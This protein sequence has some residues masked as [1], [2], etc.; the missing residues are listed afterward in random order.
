MRSRLLKHP[1][2]NSLV[3]GALVVGL[4]N[5]LETTLCWG[6]DFL[7]L[8]PN[9]GGIEMAMFSAMTLGVTGSWSAFVWGLPIGKLVGD[10]CALGRRGD[11]TRARQLCTRWGVRI[12]AL[13]GLWCFWNA[14]YLAYVQYTYTSKSILDMLKVFI[15]CSATSTPF[16]AGVLL[17]LVSQ[18]WSRP[19]EGS[20][21]V[22]ENL[23]L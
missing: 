5:I 17:V 4:I 9:R 15:F 10:A 12:A 6:V 7:F 11:Q 19:I 16:Q 1:V 21:Q 22:T 23:R 3:L 14:T 13:N 2:R 20:V 18:F 8:E